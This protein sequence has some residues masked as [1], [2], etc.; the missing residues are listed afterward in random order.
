MASRN[1]EKYKNHYKCFQKSFK[2]HN[3]ELFV[4]NHNTFFD[5]KNLIINSMYFKLCAIKLLI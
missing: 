4:V 2:L 5:K 1:N 3:L